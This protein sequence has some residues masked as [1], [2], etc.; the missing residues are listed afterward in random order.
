MS[1]GQ[2][3][4][5]RRFDSIGPR[6]D[7]LARLREHRG[8]EYARVEALRTMEEALQAVEGR[9]TLAGVYE[10]EDLAVDGVPAGQGCYRTEKS[11]ALLL[12]IDQI[13]CATGGYYVL[14]RDDEGGEA[15]G[16]VIEPAPNRGLSN[17]QR[18]SAEAVVVALA[19]FQRAVYKLRNMR[20]V[21]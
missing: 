19:S 14:L 7:G 16:E 10:G 21:C 3:Y 2:V 5:S 8:D 20:G 4:A 9:E 11:I 17:R 18:A 1:S 15:E 13:V 6:R 12:R